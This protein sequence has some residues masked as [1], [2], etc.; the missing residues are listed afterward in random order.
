[1]PLFWNRAGLPIGIQLAGRVG[2]DGTLLRLAGQLERA[3]P[4][5]NRYP[6]GS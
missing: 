6:N 2:E 4:W 5:W 3:R 1:V